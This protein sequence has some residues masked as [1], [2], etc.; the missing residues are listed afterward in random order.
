M[1][2]LIIHQVAWGEPYWRMLLDYCIPSII[3]SYKLLTQNG[4]KTDWVVHTDN[5]QLGRQYEGASIEYRRMSPTGL[6]F[7]DIQEMI[8][9]AAV[10]GCY[11]AIIAADSVH[12]KH[13]LWNAYQIGRGKDV[14]V[15]VA[16][17][18]VDCNKFMATFPPGRTYGHSEL[19]RIAMRDE[20]IHGA[21]RHS[22]DDQDDNCAN[23]GVS[24]RR[25]GG[26]RYAV[27]HTLASPM[28]LK[29]TQADA[30]WYRQFPQGE[31]D[32]GLNSML[33]SQQRI[34]LAASSDLCFFV[35]LTRPDRNFPPLRKNFKNGDRHW[36]E[37]ENIWNNTCIL[38][39]GGG[40]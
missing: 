17:P 10:E 8:S 19:V 4:V 33:F 2:K 14:A 26:D 20:I 21:T 6:A 18:R 31:F 13:T 29:P 23:W 40:D 34:K 9:Q 5:P 25:I 32:R 24:I 37:R 3:P 12:A 35:E 39:N 7:P 15:A 36:N 30:L 38:W 11:I 27:I 28:I 16:N 1:E 22:F